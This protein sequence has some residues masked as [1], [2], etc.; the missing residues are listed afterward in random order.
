MHGP[1]QSVKLNLRC[2]SDAY[3][4]DLNANIDQPM[5]T[6]RAAKTSELGDRTTAGK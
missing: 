4:M 1:E 6:A 2:A 5:V 3:N